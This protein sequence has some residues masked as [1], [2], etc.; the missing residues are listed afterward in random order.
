M[1]QLFAHWLIQIVPAGLDCLSHCVRLVTQIPQ[2]LG[3]SDYEVKFVGSQSLVLAREWL[4]PRSTSPTKSGARS[5]WQRDATPAIL[6]PRFSGVNTGSTLPLSW[7]E[8]G[9]LTGQGF[10]KRQSQ[11][12]PSTQS[13]PKASTEK[14]SRCPKA[15]PAP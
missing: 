15:G 7:K 13:L 5:T 10:H 4:K 1:L 3:E 8:T 14:E 2:F 9:G 6:L 11:R 12:K